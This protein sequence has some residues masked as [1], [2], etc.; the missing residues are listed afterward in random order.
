MSVLCLLTGSSQHLSVAASGYWYLLSGCLSFAFWPVQANVCLL[1][2]PVTGTY[3]VDVC[4]SPSDRFK[5]TSVHCCFRFLVPTKR[6]SVLHLLTGSSQHLSIAASGYWYLPSR[7]LSFAF[8]PVQAHICL[9]PLPVTGT[10]QAD[11]CLCLPTGSKP[12]SVLCL[13]TGPNQRLSFAFRPVQT[14]VCPSPS[15]RSKP[16]S[17]LCLPT[18]PSQRLSIALQPARANVCPPPSTCRYPPTSTDQPVPSN[19]YPP[20]GASPTG[21]SLTSTL[22][23]LPSKWY[24]PT[25]TFPPVNSNRCTFPPFFQY[26]ANLIQVP[27]TVGTLPSRAYYIYGVTLV[28]LTAVQTTTFLS[29]KLLSFNQTPALQPNHGPFK[30]LK[31]GNIQPHPW[32]CPWK[33]WWVTIEDFPYQQWICWHIWLG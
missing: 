1:L 26:F 25:G 8:W 11:V 18:G 30:A 29:T 13:P 28:R 20:I 27:F 19:R 7:H 32:C 5:L 2:L 14:N 24:P 16:T 3:Q 6:T 15:D 33:W 12:T 23:P 10:Q 4:P 9:S 21:T 31:E 17:V 22:R